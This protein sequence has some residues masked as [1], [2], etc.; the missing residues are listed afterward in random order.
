MAD[1]ALDVPQ[2]QVAIDF[3]DDPEGLQWHVRLLFFG[4]DRGQWVGCSPDHEFEIVDLT[5][6]RVVALVRNAEFPARLAGITYAFDPLEAGELAR[7]E[8]EARDFAAVVGFAAA[9]PV[10]GRWVVSDPSHEA[11][12]Q[13]VPARVYAE[14]EHCVV[15]GRVALVQI[16]D[17]WTTAECI[18]KEED[19]HAR[20]GGGPGR[21]AR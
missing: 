7:L 8:R 4:N 2:R 17:E 9:A 12:G 3:F 16:D 19:W 6:H 11:F 5:A 18:D 20:R 21:D 13:E 15:R 1:R 14:A 10:E